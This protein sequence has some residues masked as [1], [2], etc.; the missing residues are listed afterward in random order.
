ME[1]V[2]LAEEVLPLSI[3]NEELRHLRTLGELKQ[4]VTVKLSVAP[5]SSHE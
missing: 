5:S 2:I 3:G 4:F 1:I